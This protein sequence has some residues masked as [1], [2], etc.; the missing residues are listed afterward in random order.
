MVNLYAPYVLM[1]VC[2][3]VGTCDLGQK[4]ATFF[5]F[6]GSAYFYAAY[7][8]NKKGEL[9][10]IHTHIIHICLYDRNGH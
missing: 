4:S 1:Y 9:T 8:Q 6:C 3:F 5:F 7:L 2:M 10:H